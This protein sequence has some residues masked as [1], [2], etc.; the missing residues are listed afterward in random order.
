MSF[1]YLCPGGF[2]VWVV[3]GFK[4]IRK[5]SQWTITW[6]TSES[7]PGQSCPETCSPILLVTTQMAEVLSERYLPLNREVD[8][9]HI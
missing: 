8:A 2:L 9:G 5:M 4:V 1:A 6:K 3:L 7:L